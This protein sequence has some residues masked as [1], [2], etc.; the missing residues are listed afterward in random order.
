MLLWKADRVQSGYT[1]CLLPPSGAD[2]R[3]TIQLLKGILRRLIAI[4]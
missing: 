4:L 2:R 1:E 3:K